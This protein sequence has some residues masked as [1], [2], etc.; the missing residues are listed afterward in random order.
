MGAAKDIAEEMELSKSTAHVI[1]QTL[2]GLGFLETTEHNDKRYVLGVEGYT[3]GMK[4]LANK[5]NIHSCSSE[6]ARLAEKWNKIGFV[7]VLK[8]GSIVY[9]QK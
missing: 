4:Y 6:L 8:G 5:D 7:G 9:V 3:L 1:I 2:Y